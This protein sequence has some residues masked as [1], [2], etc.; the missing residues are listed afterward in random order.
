MKKILAIALALCMVI[1]VCSCGKTDSVSSSSDYKIAMITDYG[2]IT[3]QSFNQITYEACKKFGADNN[4]EFTYFKPIHDT[5]AERVA[6]VDMAV[7]EGYNII[8]M[9]GCVFPATIVEVAPLYKDVKFVAL[10]VS[11]ND[12]LQ[13]AVGAKY[14]SKPENWNLSDYVDLSN[15]YS[16]IFQEELSGFMAGYAAVKL[17][18]SELGF[19][20]GMAVPAVIRYGFGFVQGAD[21]AAAE[22]GVK[23]N[24]KYAYANQFFGDADITAAMDTWCLD[25]TQVIFACGGGVYTSVAEAAS[26]TGS[27]VIGVDVDQKATIDGAYG[28]GITLT[29]AMKGIFAATT[30]VLDDIVN[31]NAWDKYAGKI[32]TLGLVSGTEPEENFCQLPMESTQFNSGFTKEDYKKLVSEMF[33]GELKVSNNVSVEMIPSKV[34]TVDF[35]GNIK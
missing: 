35:Q 1:A 16:A 31:N 19:V 5:T 34:V 24:V 32:E 13:E 20:G 21:V 15:V 18:Y 33:S 22:M 8:V 28:E 30:D 17:G 7:A 3:D 29:S 11:E 6:M 23:A 10:D 25:G 4:V 9:P 27:K 12:L 26:K 14:D 2:D